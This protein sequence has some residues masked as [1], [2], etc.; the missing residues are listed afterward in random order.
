MSQPLL[1]LK[2]EIKGNLSLSLPL[3]SAQLIYATSGFVGTVLVAKLGEDA[4]AAS[5]LVSTIWM[6]LSVLFFGILNAVSVLVSHQFG[7]KNYEGI[8]EIMGQ[9]YLLGI[10]LTIVMIIMLQTMPWFLHWSTQPHHVLELSYQYMFA[11]LWTIPGLLALIITEQ[12]LTGINRGKMVLRISILVVP[13]EIIWIYLL[14]FGKFGL[15]ACGI[16]GIGYG[17]ATTYSLTSILLFFYLLNSK[18]YSH[19]KIFKDILRIKWHYLKDLITIGLPMGFMHVIELSTFA[20]ATFWIAQF[21][22]TMLAAHQIVFQY[23]GFLITI[24]FGMS[25]AVTVRVGHAIG[26]QDFPAITYAAIAGMFLNSIFIIGIAIA[27]IFLPKFFLSIDINTTSPHHATLVRDASSLLAIGGILLIFDNIRIIGFGALRGLKDT[28][29]PM[30]A[31]FIGFWLI[32]LS[33]AYLF[34]FV[35]DFQG[36]GIWWGLTLGI[37]SSSVIVIAR[38]WYKLTLQPV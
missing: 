28:R 31:A 18:E 33:C 38:L 12:F 16:A 34:S 30:Y 32:G 5:V 20:I 15:P 14:I 1:A 3:I 9:S 27:F 29:F 6:A 26:R 2:N 7:A 35:L 25:Q 36:E 24:V 13:I 23:L 11:L 19:F 8:S 17:F 4:L 21:G 37:A 10:L 22:T